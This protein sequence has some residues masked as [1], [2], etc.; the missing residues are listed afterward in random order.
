MTQLTPF[1]VS[2]LA[3]LHQQE[4]RTEAERSRLSAQACATSRVGSTTHAAR[5]TPMQTLKTLALRSANVL[6]RDCTVSLRSV[7]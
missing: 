3:A 2:R 6:Q 7:A 4:L 5:I 1:V